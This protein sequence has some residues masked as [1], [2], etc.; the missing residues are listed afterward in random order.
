MLPRFPLAPRSGERVP[1]SE[2]PRRERGEN[3]KEA[4]SPGSLLTQ[5]AT[6]SRYA[7][8]G[9][10]AHPSRISARVSA[11]ATRHSASMSSSLR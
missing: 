6:L 1:R 2:G 3:P 9:N 4:P 11:T 10:Y 7:G 8:E 5:L